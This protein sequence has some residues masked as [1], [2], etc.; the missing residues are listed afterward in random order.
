MKKI[1]I[2]SV[3][4]SLPNPCYNADDLCTELF[5]FESFESARNAFYDKYTELAY[6]SNEMFENGVLRARDYY[7]D[8]MLDDDID[9]EFFLTKGLCNEIKLAI[10]RILYKESFGLDIRYGQYD[11]GMIALKVSKG[12]IKIFGINDGPING[13]DPF[14]HTNAFDMSEEKDYFLYISDL[15]GQDDGSSELYIDLQEVELC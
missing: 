3:R 7:I 5:A 2:L 8:D 14:I 1:W 13:Y 6:S 12:E 9:D 10:H 15:F 11:D 4:T